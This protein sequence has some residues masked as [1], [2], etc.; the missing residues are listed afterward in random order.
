[1]TCHKRDERLHEVKVCHEAL[2]TSL[3][4]KEMQLPSNTA[5]RRATLLAASAFA[6]ATN[7]LCQHEKQCYVCRQIYQRRSIN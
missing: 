6:K 5:A 3:F 2:L 4:R 7:D 1:M